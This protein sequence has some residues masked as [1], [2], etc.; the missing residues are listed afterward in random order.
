M[1][2]DTTPTQK[3]VGRWTKHK[4]TSGKIA[5]DRSVDLDSQETLMS[6]VLLLCSSA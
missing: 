4:S 3:Y 1:I 5:G 2:F 6:G